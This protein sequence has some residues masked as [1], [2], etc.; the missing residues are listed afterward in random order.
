M[1]GLDQTDRRFFEKYGYVVVP[2]VVPGETCARLVD[3]IDD[4]LGNDS[5]NPDSWYQIPDHVDPQAIRVGG[6]PLM[7]AA[8]QWAVRQSPALYAVFAELLGTEG[9]WVVPDG[10]DFAPPYRD[11][12]GVG[13]AIPLH[14]EVE[15]STLRNGEGH[16][17]GTETAPFGISGLAVLQDATPDH[18]SFR[19]VPELY[20]E[21]SDGSYFQTETDVSRLNVDPGDRDVETVTPD[22]GSVILWDRRLPHGTGRNTAKEPRYAQYLQM[23]PEA[24]ADTNR[25]HERIMDFKQADD[26]PDL[27]PL[28]R[29]LLGLDPWSGWLY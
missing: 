9:L 26:H 10:A 23:V 18:G 3:R 6:V 24:F 11:T 15:P 25:R 20:R 28:G 19:C 8:E 13:E 17:D 16:V 27:T 5:T 1:T 21:V 14:W 7:Q 4:F 29:R 2:N 22:R 12:T